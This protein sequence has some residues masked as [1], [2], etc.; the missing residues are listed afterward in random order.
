MAPDFPGGRKQ[1]ERL[2]GG[3]CG[4][5]CLCL[6]R[7][8]SVRQREGQWKPE[9]WVLLR[10]TLWWLYIVML[11]VLCSTLQ[12]VILKRCYINLIMCL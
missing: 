8:S 6:K 7:F 10:W 3:A 12:N 11:A 2:P 4:R 1:K 5:V 9:L